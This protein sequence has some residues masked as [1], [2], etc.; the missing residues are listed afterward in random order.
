MLQDFDVLFQKSLTK[1]QDMKPVA[2]IVAPVQAM[3]L[4]E[5]QGSFNPDTEGVA[6]IMLPQNGEFRY[7]NYLVAI[8]YHQWNFNFI[9]CNGDS[10]PL[11]INQ[12]NPRVVRIEPENSVVTKIVVN[13][14]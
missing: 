6:S 2:N 9:L 4:R 12:A 13:Y 3:I 1:L 7:E 14:D 8:E 11:L 5:V 10:T